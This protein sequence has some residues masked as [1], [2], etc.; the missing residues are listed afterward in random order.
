MTTITPI[1]AM[2]PPESPPPRREAT[3]CKLLRSAWASSRSLRDEPGD[4]GLSGTES[5]GHEA[6]A[7]ARIGLVED[8][9]EMILQG[10]L[11]QVKGSRCGPGV[12]TGGDPAQHLVLP[13]G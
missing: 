9:L 5:C 2:A 1:L 11:G 6:S 12:V 8:R 13:R 4:R 10:V 7:V 3:L